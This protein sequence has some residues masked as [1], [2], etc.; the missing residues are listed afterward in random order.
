MCTCFFCIGPI[1]ACLY[2]LIII[3]FNLYENYDDKHTN[4]NNPM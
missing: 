4:M 1:Y 2:I 3:T